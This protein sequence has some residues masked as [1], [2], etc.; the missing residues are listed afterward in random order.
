MPGPELGSS[1]SCFSSTR[2]CSF[3]WIS[4][5]EIA[6]EH[7][8]SVS[9]SSPPKAV[10]RGRTYPRIKCQEVV[11]LQRGGTAHGEMIPPMSRATD[12]C[13]AAMPGFSLASTRQG[14]HQYPE[15]RPVTAATRRLRF[16]DAAPRCQDEK[17]LTALL[18]A[19]AV[20]HA[21]L[22]RVRCS[23]FGVVSLPRS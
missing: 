7:I 3:L 14:P 4:L 15:L 21:P 11:S 16:E 13:A 19:A 20:L 17:I 18:A 10:T 8:C 2:C 12:H 5:Y 22:H 9:F 6:S 1:S 23:A